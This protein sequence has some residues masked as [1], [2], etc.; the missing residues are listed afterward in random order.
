[1][2]KEEFNLS[3]KIK[4]YFNYTDWFSWVYLVIMFYVIKDIIIYWNTLERWKWGYWSIDLIPATIFLF[5]L[6]ILQTI[7]NYLRISK[8]VSKLENNLQKIGGNRK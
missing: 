8:R 7:I 6:F 5:I 2:K 1:M 3:E 4:K